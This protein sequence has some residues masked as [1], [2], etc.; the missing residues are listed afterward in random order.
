M[1]GR[2][3][4]RAAAGSESVVATAAAV[5]MTMAAGSCYQEQ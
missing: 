2:G 3:S 4:G 5:I 1:W